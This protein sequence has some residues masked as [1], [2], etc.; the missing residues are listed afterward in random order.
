MLLVNVIRYRGVQKVLLI[1][2]SINRGLLLVTWR[3]LTPRVTT[4]IALHCSS[5]YQVHSSV[6]SMWRPNSSMRLLIADRIVWHLLL[7]LLMLGHRHVILI[8]LLGWISS[9]NLLLLLHFATLVT[10][11]FWR[12]SSL[13]FLRETTWVSSRRLFAAHLLSSSILRSCH[14]WMHHRHS[15]VLLPASDTE[16]VRH[17]GLERATS[18]ESLLLLVK[19]LRFA[20]RSWLLADRFGKNGSWNQLLLLL[21]MLIELLLLL[22]YRWMTLSWRSSSSWNVRKLNLSGVL[23]LI[24]LVTLERG[25]QLLSMQVWIGTGIDI[26]VA[27]LIKALHL[28]R[29]VIASRT[30]TRRSLIL[31]LVL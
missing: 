9:I 29:F 27:L 10:T 28:K 23:I 21:C 17:I 7:I 8:L 13:S 15:V 1:R 30:S 4:V 26:R 14:P 24:V 22:N 11:Q 19:G 6:L 31:I 20:S 16:S 3:V 25:I 5:H 2:W 12:S 18:W